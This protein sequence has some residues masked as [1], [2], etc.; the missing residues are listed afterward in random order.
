MTTKRTRWL[1]WVLTL[2]I[3]TALLVPGSALALPVNPPKIGMVCMPPTTLPSTFDLVATTGSIQTPEGNQ[4]FMW[5]YADSSSQFQYPGP[6]LCV[7]EGD[8]VTVNLIN[9]L[10]EASSIVFP[11]QEGVTATGGSAGFLTTEAA[12]SVGTVSYSFTAGSPGT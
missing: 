3:S 10:P 5:S 7:T 6:V 9:N 11:G 4:I 12:A 2:A 1:G 8:T